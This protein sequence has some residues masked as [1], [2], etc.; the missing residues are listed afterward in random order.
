MI[1]FLLI[2][3][4]IVGILDIIYIDLV[5]DYSSL[6]L[7]QNKSVLKKTFSDF[8]EG[9]KSKSKEQ[10]IHMDHFY[11]KRDKNYGKPSAW[12]IYYLSSTALIMKIILL[13]NIFDRFN[14]LSNILKMIN[15]ILINL[16]EN[17]SLINFI[18]YI[19]INLLNWI[20]YFL[21]HPLGFRLIASIILFKFLFIDILSFLKTYWRQ[22]GNSLYIL[23]YYSIDKN[24]T[25]TWKLTPRRFKRNCRKI[26]E[27]MNILES[28]M[29][30]FDK[31]VQ[32]YGP[33]LLDSKENK[34]KNIET[35]MRL[36]SIS[37]E[38]SIKK[39]ENFLNKYIKAW[40]DRDAEKIAK[41]YDLDYIQ[42]LNELNEEQDK[43]N[44]IYNEYLSWKT[45][46]NKGD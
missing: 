35:K 15:P 4:I 18:K 8:C 23:N 43:I 1:D 34:I 37:C 5:E 7:F 38:T 11:H 9:L 13:F 40:E 28:Q 19:F 30:K 33:K 3:I 31:I 20:S 14:L 44:N 21:F 2:Q 17:T 42:L 22:T 39:L 6:F 26:A 16:K 10:W 29:N 46:E 32:T 25:I 12:L 24:N 41:L 27:L 45:T 36:V